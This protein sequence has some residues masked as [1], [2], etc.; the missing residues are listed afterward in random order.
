MKIENNWKVWDKN[1][2]YGETLYKR[3]IGE[4]PEMESSK[5]MAKE[6]A[7]K[8]QNYDKVLDVGCGSGHYLRSF[9]REIGNDFYYTGI[10][11]TEEY[12][13][14]ARKAFKSDPN[15][16]FEVSDIYSIDIMDA[17]YDIVT[18]N[19]VLLHLPS[20]E[21]PINELI[22]VGKKFILI[23]FLCGEHSFRIKDVNLETEEYDEN[24]E[25]LN[26][27]YFNIYSKKY[28][29]KIIEK[30]ERVKSWSIEED[31]DF[32]KER[33]RNSISDHKGAINAT[34]II[35]KYQVNVYILL[36]WSILTIELK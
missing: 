5:K 32:D 33:I 13:E 31:I 12:I 23:R 15:S 26:Y 36:P 10:D 9:R 24:G 25:P 3:A 6:L 1:T 27:Y 29:Q 2:N 11:A 8:I 21:I 34:K 14:F 4:L 35:D 7:K 16:N 18:C 19:N 28:I 17:S 22:R 20:I 30:N